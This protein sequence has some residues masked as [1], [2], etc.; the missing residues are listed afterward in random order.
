M[1]KTNE[2]KFFAVSALLALVLVGAGL[3]KRGAANRV[4][5]AEEE[6]VTPLPPGV[7]ASDAL[8]G[9]NPAL[10][11]D[12]AP[13]TIVE[14]GDSQCP[15]CAQAYT[16]L[17]DLIKHGNG[18]ARLVFRN[19]PLTNLHPNALNAAL[20]AEAAGEQGKFWAM[21]DLLYTQPDRL[22]VADLNQAAETMHLDL[23]RFHQS[24][25]RPAK[26]R[27]RADLAAVERLKITG[28]PALLLCE[29]GGS[30]RAISMAELQRRFR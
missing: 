23:P 28:T 21:H 8:N 25:R 30:V 17:N 11:P 18:Q 19:Y 27:V 3:A 4:S 16:F 26:A 22:S 15:P 9:A 2:G 1:L 6:I 12:D 10:G 14:F 20:V 5:T 29:P 13:Y 7:T 24:L